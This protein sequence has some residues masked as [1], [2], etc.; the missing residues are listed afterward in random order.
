MSNASGP[1]DNPII[2]NAVPEYGGTLIGAIVSAALWGISCMQMLIHVFSELRLRS[3]V[4]QA[5]GTS[6]FSVPRRYPKAS[7]KVVYVWVADTLVEALGF[8]GIFDQLII[9][10]GSIIAF[11]TIMR[12][13]VDSSIL[14]ESGVDYACHYDI[15]EAS[16]TCSTA[17]RKAMLSLSQLHASSSD[18]WSV[19]CMDSPYVNGLC[20]DSRQGAA[21]TLASQRIVTVEIIS[22]AIPAFVDIFIALWMTFLLWRSKERARVFR[23]SNRLILRL[24][25]LTINAG[26]WT[27]VLSII[28]LSLIA[29]NPGKLIFDAFEFPLASLYLNMLLASLNAR[30]FLRRSGGSV[31]EVRLTALEL[32]ARSRQSTGLSFPLTSDSAALGRCEDSAL[33]IR[34]D[35]SMT[36]HSDSDLERNAKN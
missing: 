25:L 35:K 21:A 10:W 22:R 6:H 29:W 12:T 2:I 32:D 9:R 17:M 1:I 31:G 3:L 14:P 28:D 27:A 7:Y 20:R 26:I 11:D 30:R 36:T 13:L 33:A 34:I 16:S 23:R 18:Y 5:L 8:A 24:M 4:A 15:Y 19:D